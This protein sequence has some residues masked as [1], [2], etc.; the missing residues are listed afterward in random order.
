[1]L[2]SH[3]KEYII[4]PTLDYMG[5]NSASAVNLLLGTAA[6]ESHLG[7]YLHQING[8][9]LGIYQMEPDTHKDIHNNFLVYKSDLN[10]KILNLSFPAFSMKKNLIGNLYYATAMARIHYYRVPEKLPKADDIE[11]LANYWKRYYNTT[12]GK[13]TIKEFIKN[14]EK[15]VLDC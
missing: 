6:Q 8:P 14:F 3:L 9:A 7:K 12:I 5:L 2:A 1:M 4:I 15:Y 11:G 10:K 13:G